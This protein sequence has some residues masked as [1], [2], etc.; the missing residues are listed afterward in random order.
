LAAGLLSV[1]WAA[2]GAAIPASAD[3]APAGGAQTSIA[4]G[5]LAKLIQ[6]GKAPLILDVRSPKE[7]AE[8]HIPGSVNIPYDQ[9]A[10]HLSEL[11]AA[12]TDE[13]VVHCASGYRAGKAEKVLHE[14]GYSDVRDLDGHMNGWKAGGYPIEKP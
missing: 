11:H 12:K 7:Y 2:N 13:I 9:L 5:E 4:P 1:V 10:D 8:G 6:A 14:A 3:D